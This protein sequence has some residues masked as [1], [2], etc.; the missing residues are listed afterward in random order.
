MKILVVDNNAESVKYLKDLLKELKGISS[1]YESDTAEKALYTLLE[2]QPDI[3]VCSDNLNGKGAFDLAY[4]IERENIQVSTIILSTNQAKAIDAIRAKIFDFILVPCSD[5][6]LKE[7]VYKT[8]DDVKQ[9]RMA[10]KK[11][12]DERVSKLR[13]TT[14]NGFILFDINTLVYCEADGSYTHLFFENGNTEY[15][16]YYLGKIERLLKEY[17][18][19]RISRSVLVNNS[20]I[21]QIDKR[22]NQCVVRRGNQLLKLR[23]SVRSIKW[24]DEE[25]LN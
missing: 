24:L 22:N 20:K 3:L 13:L 2:K 25:H 19:S 18:F 6:K 4:L 15:S 17:G 12:V 9:R 10:S 5:E 7:S 16:S 11:P 23:F 8:I 21:E 14:T 1:I